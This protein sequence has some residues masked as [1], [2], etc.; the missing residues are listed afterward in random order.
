MK[1]N[2]PVYLAIYSHLRDQII[3]G[4]LSPGQILPS[5]NELCRT[6][7]TTRETVRRGL[8]LLTQEGLIYSRPKRGYFVSE[9]K[10]NDISLTLGPKI[11]ESVSIFKDIRLIHPDAELQDALQ[12]PADQRIIALYRGSY[13]EQKQIGLEIKYTP[14]GKGIP[15]IENEIHYAVFP[16]AADAKTDSF[17]Y[18]TQLE[19]TAVTPTSEI[20]AFLDCKESDPLLL[21]RRLFITQDGRRIGYS[22][23]YLKQ[24]SCCLS[25]YSGYVQNRQD[26]ARASRKKSMKKSS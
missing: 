26:A 15:S 12:V 14:Y 7:S 24:P 23:E 17:S 8:Q 11:T 6:F 19:I 5:E 2:N 22:K 18:Y 9:P 3:D 13:H 25:G 20:L 16:E 10:N 4:T 21:I 1:T